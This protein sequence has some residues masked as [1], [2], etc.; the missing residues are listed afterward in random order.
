LFV[1]GAIFSGLATLIV[2][3]AILRRI[4]RWEEYITELYFKYLGYL[5]AILAVFMIYMNISPDPSGVSRE[6]P[7]SPKVRVS[8]RTLSAIRPG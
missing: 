6:A 4:Y 5:M 1:A 8:K 2:V 7:C 3:L